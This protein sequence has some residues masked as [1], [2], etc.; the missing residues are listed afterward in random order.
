MQ[1]KTAVNSKSLPVQI[2]IPALAILVSQLYYS[3][4]LSRFQQKLLK[5]SE[6][7]VDG[8][9]GGS[10]NKRRVSNGEGDRKRG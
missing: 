6:K 2:K 4:P 3:S 1:K 10:G 5:K 7:G 8:H 9:E